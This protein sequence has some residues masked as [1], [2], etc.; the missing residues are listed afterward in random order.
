MAFRTMTCQTAVP[1]RWGPDRTTGGT[2]MPCCPGRP[3][4]SPR[5]TAGRSRRHPGRS[6]AW[7]R[8][9][10][11]SRGEA[12][13][14][15]RSARLRAPARRVRAAAMHG[16]APG[17]TRYVPPTRWCCRR[18][19]AGPGRAPGAGTGRPAR[20]AR[21]AGRA[22]R[23]PVI[24]AVAL[25]AAAVAIGRARRRRRRLT[26]SP[27]GSP[28]ARSARPARPRRSPGS[29]GLAAT[30]DAARDRDPEAR[31]DARCARQPRRPASEVRSALCREY[32]ASSRT[33][34]RAERR[35]LVTL[36]GQ[37][38]ELAGGP[39]R[40]R[41]LLRYLVNPSR[42]GR[43]PLPEP[44]PG[45]RAEGAR[46]G[47]P[48][49]GPRTRRSGQRRDRA[50]PGHSDRV[51]AAVPRRGLALVRRRSGVRPGQACSASASTMAEQASSKAARWASLSR[52]KTSRRTAA[53]C[54]GA[55]VADGVGARG[56]E[57][58]ERAPPVGR[59]L[60]P[61]RPARGAPSG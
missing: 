11:S 37:L 38:S 59:A 8:R 14:G 1:P 57:L 53:T 56:G 3:P 24:A 9:C 26:C 49:L 33:D 45:R 51:G 32:F 25:L 30:K 28:P 6:S 17:R 36:G 31:S 5:G 54:R 12:M 22:A 13:A 20:Q 50:E 10:A 27:G 43:R 2:S 16:S 23:W 42:P 7:P 52:S 58:D 21:R 34:A 55:A 40:S 61:L 15:P 60:L 44:M 19:A 29:Q 35:T 47:G 41:V 18:P 4:S 39:S 46:H 48:G